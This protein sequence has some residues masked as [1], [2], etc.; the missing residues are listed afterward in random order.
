MKIEKDMSSMI[1]NFS[2]LDPS[3]PQTSQTS[4]NNQHGITNSEFFDKNS[5]KALENEGQNI[6]VLKEVS[7]NFM[8]KIAKAKRSEAVK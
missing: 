2:K 1:S 8:R 6:Y 4:Q 3:I 5:F 7:S